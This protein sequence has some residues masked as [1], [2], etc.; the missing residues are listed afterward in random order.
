[1]F[2][3][4][5]RKMKKIIV[6]VALLVGFTS[7]TNDIKTN[8]PAF[9]GKLGDNFWRATF[10]EATINELGG[11]TITA[12]SPFEEVTLQTASINPGTYV[13]GTTNQ[14][15]FASYY[16]ERNNDIASYETS[17][18]P[19]AVNQIAGIINGGSGYTSTNNGLTTG[20]SGMGLRFAVT[21]NN[22]NGTISNVQIIARGAGYLAGDEVTI[23]GGNGQARVRILNVQQ[24]NGEIIIESVEEGRATGTFKFTAVDNEGNTVSLSQGNF[25]RIPIR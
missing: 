15:N 18:F 12:L 21:V 24:S 8:D 11:L 13:L 6:L 20:G 10:A 7:C 19:G 3:F 23:L 17:L 14:N 25:Y 4:K 22:L 16:F 5:I 2:A 9:Q 1:M